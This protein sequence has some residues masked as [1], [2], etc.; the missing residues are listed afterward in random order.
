[1]RETHNGLCGIS[2]NNN[3]NKTYNKTKEKER[4]EGFE[5]KPETKKENSRPGSSLSFEKKP[6]K[7]IEAGKRGEPPVGKTAPETQ[8]GGGYNVPLPFAYNQNQKDITARLNAISKAWNASGVPLPCRKIF[9]SPPETANMLPAL[10]S[11]PDDLILQAVR[12]Y[13][14]ACKEPAV[15]RVKEDGY[16]KSIGLPLAWI[17]SLPR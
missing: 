15:Y 9:F 6:D 12:N 10:Q 14:A 17:R 16:G 2:G 4:E 7:P 3:N 8:E 5:K 13:A 11:Y 1:M